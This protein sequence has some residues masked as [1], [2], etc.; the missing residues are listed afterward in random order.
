MCNKL[1]PYSKIGNILQTNNYTSIFST[2]HTLGNQNIKNL[3]V[4]TTRLVRPTGQ[5]VYS[6]I[7]AKNAHF[8][9]DL[10]QATLPAH[11][12]S[13]WQSFIKTALPRGLE[14]QRFIQLILSQPAFNPTAD[15][16]NWFSS[17]SKTQKG[18]WNSLF[19]SPWCPLAVNR[20]PLVLN[21]PMSPTSPFCGPLLLKKCLWIHAT[22]FNFKGQCYKEG[23][24]A[25]FKI[26]I[27][28]FRI[29]S[30]RDIWSQAYTTHKPQWLGCSWPIMDHSS[31]CSTKNTP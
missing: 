21:M 3:Q 18:A 1:P 29:V 10:W 28:K 14:A 9:Q 22:A 31:L 23:K 27:M 19:L 30:W 20:K 24:V 5:L 2:T 26:L 6:I 13:T 7:K 15:L 11:G 4:G 8:E 25:V 16:L 12:I 17:T